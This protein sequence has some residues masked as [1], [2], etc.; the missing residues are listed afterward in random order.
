[1]GFFLTI[2]GYRLE[3]DW[4]ELEIFVLDI[5]QGKCLLAEITALCLAR[6]APAEG[7]SPDAH[8]EEAGP[9]R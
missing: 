6:S 4:H 8:G 1:M 5:V 3:G 2:N 7:R 9:Q